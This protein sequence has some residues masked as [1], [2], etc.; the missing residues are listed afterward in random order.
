MQSVDQLQGFTCECTTK[1][2]HGCF[3]MTHFLIISLLVMKNNTVISTLQTEDA[4][5][6]QH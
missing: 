6:K 5:D 1:Y 2:Y 4:S 3:L